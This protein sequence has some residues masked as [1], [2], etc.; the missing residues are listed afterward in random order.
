[1]SWIIFT[2]HLLPREDVKSKV[3]IHYS[4][5]IFPS[6]Y[7][8][9]CLFEAGRNRRSPW[10]SST[11]TRRRSIQICFCYLFP[12]YVKNLGK[13]RVHSFVICCWII[14]ASNNQFSQKRAKIKLRHST[15][16]VV[17]VKIWWFYSIA[18]WITTQVTNMSKKRLSAKKQE[19]TTC[20]SHQ[21]FKN[22]LNVVSLQKIM[23][24]R[25]FY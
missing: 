17:T 2:N 12:R 9:K 5:L 1:M 18:Y 21:Y 25:Y 3:N 8:R 13:F 15:V 11:R 16:I 7:F 20:Q 22:N 23:I 6:I 10:R 19:S 4:T 14:C 24:T